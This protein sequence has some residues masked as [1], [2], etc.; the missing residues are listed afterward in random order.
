M[1]D[2]V[3]A[4]VGLILLMPVFIA[5]IVCIKIEDPK[6]SVFFYQNRV[7]RNEQVFKMF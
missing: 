7:G 6:G 2:L 4:I 3:G 1:I 5:V